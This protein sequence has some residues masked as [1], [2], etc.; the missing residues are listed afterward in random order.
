MDIIE[1]VEAT[2]IDNGMPVVILPAAAFG[3]TCGESPDALE[4]DTELRARIEAIRR[5]AGPMMNL[6]DVRDASVPKMTL[7]APPRQGGTIATRSFIPHR[8][9]KAIGVFA[10]VSVGHAC[11]LGE[12]PAARAAR[13]PARGGQVTLDIEHPTGTFGV[14][15]HLTPDGSPLSGGVLRTARKLMDGRVFA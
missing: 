3:I 11:L 5:I 4:A 12:G 13:L 14:V 8:C 9:H 15:F 1:G 10:A 2:L 7:A 6:G